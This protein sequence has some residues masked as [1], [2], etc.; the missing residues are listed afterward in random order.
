MNA[1]TFPLPRSRRARI[2]AIVAHLIELL[3]AMDDTDGD[4]CAAE[5]LPP[6][7]GARGAGDEDDGEAEA[8]PLS[9]S[10]TLAPQ[11]RI[12]RGVPALRHH[13]L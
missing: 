12:R 11:K 7:A 6:P 3:D 13:A 10:A 1:L 5:D 9:L 4:A 2:E 8:V